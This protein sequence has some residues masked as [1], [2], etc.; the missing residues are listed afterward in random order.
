MR[1][2]LNDWYIMHADNLFISKKFLSAAIAPPIPELPHVYINGTARTNYSNFPACIKF[3][4]DNSKIE[5]LET[6]LAVSVD[7]VCCYAVYDKKAVY[8]MGTAWPQFT[9]F[10][11]REYSKW[12]N[13]E[14]VVRVFTK[15][16]TSIQKQYNFEMNT[17]DVVDQVMNVYRPDHSWWRNQKPWWA[18]WIW[19]LRIALCAGYKIHILASRDE[20]KRPISHLMYHKMISDWLLGVGEHKKKR[21][22]SQSH[23]AVSPIPTDPTNL[24][25]AV[26]ALRA[27]PC[28]VISTVYVPTTLTEDSI[29][30]VPRLDGT[31]HKISTQ[32]SSREVTKTCQWCRY[33]WDKLN[34]RP[35]GS[36]RQQRAHLKCDV[37][38]IYF[39]SPEC[40]TEFHTKED[41]SPQE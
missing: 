20:G 36:K 2:P 37:C 39:C 32:V 23:P 21:Q 5:T 16:R 12:D 4:V 25:E 31:F 34:I 18:L 38:R 11:T 10:V 19:C 33:K 28:T 13:A 26:D 29:K 14:Q 3:A 6:R 40:Y 1:Y 7:G 15:W 41:L 17:I 35:K 22:R 30:L 9:K 24:D 8:F 27:L